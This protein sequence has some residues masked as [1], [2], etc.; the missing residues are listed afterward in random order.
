MERIYRQILGKEERLL[1]CRVNKLFV[2]LVRAKKTTHTVERNCIKGTHKKRKLWRWKQERD[3][4]EARKRLGRC[5][6]EVKKRQERY[7]KVA[8]RYCG[9]HPWVKPCHPETS[10]KKNTRSVTLKMK[11]ERGEKE[12]TWGVVL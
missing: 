3:E 1:R 6:K 9:R 2:W 4:N 8:R 11:Q 7:E 10:T 5:C 12:T